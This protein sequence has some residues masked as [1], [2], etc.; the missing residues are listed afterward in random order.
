MAKGAGPGRSCADPPSNTCRSWL[1]DR[2]QVDLPRRG[3]HQGIGPQVGM[4]IV[5]LA[6]VAGSTLS[7]N[8]LSSAIST[9]ARPWPSSRNGSIAQ[10][11]TPLHRPSGENSRRRHIRKL[12]RAEKR[13][14]V[15]TIN[16]AMI[17]AAFISSAP[18]RAPH[19]RS[20]IRSASPRS[21]R[22]GHS[23]QAGRAPDDYPLQRRAKLE[24]ASN[25]LRTPT[26]APKRPTPRLLI[27]ERVA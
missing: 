1:G 24:Q 6:G 11:A 5:R 23:G 27:V 19:D 26:P 20:T 22:S 14:Y 8:R 16:A 3:G 18:A 7:A 2:R 9:T 17:A 10:A 21:A 15:H 25:T 4:E 12:P 13:G